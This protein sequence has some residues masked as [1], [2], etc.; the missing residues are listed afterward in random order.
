[1]RRCVL[2]EGSLFVIPKERRQGLVE[3]IYKRSELPAGI[4][5]YASYP[6]F[7]GK[8][9]FGVLVCG[10]NRIM[11]D[12]GEYLSSL[13]GRTLYMNVSCHDTGNNL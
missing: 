12:T 1:M 4:K 2:K 8:Y 7:Y 3:D 5:G 11:M 6:L 10:I 13:L 9:L